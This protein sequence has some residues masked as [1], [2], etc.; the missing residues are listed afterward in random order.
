MAGSWGHMT[1]DDGTPFSEDMTAVMDTTGDLAEALWQCYG[2]IW[3]L[4]E[5]LAYR[6]EDPA[7]RQA[8]GRVPRERVLPYI[9][10]ARANHPE[11]VRLGKGD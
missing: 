10:R 6:D 7:T 8:L 9:E 1:N 2:M 3:W 4:A 5:A 11:G